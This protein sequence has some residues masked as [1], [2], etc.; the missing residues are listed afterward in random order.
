METR[1]ARR[2]SQGLPRKAPAYAKTGGKKEL[3]T[4]DGHWSG[5]KKG[6]ARG[7]SFLANAGSTLFVLAII[8]T[9]PFIAVIVY[10]RSIAARGSR[11]KA[12]PRIRP[13]LKSIHDDDVRLFLT[14]FALFS[15]FFAS[16]RR[17]DRWHA[18]VNLD[19]SLQ[20]IVQAFQKKGL[21]LIPEIWPSTSKRA[22]QLLG[23]YAAF[24]ALL[25][26]YLPGKRFE[27]TTTA[28]G[29]VPVYKA[30][31][32]QSLVVTVVA[33]FICWR[34]ELTSPK[35]IYDLF[36]EMLAGMA[37]FSIFFCVFLQIKGHVAP[38]DED[39]GSC[40]NPIYDFWWGME[41]YPKLG[42]LNVKQFTNCR[43]GMMA[44]AILPIIFACYQYERDGYLADSVAVTTLLMSVYNFKFFLWE[45]GYFNSMDI[46]HDRAGYYICWGCLVWVPAVYASPALYVASVTPP[47]SLG[48]TR[49]LA[50]TFLGLLSIWVNYDSDL[51][52]QLFR[53]S[54]GKKK[55]WGKKPL[56]IEAEYKV[57]KN[58]EWVTKKSLLLASGW[59]GVARHF[60]YLPEITASFF[61]TA[62]ALFDKLPPYL[63]VV[64]LTILLIDRSMRDDLRCSLKYGKHWKKYCELVP[65]KIVPGI[66]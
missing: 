56:M 4:K 46:Q 65:Y 19:G 62:P 26:V 41:L 14:P 63:Y 39:S 43:F 21:A 48:A 8:L 40:G 1:G 50:I 25:Q 29:N 36:G 10:V 35:E 49:S 60:H 33:F 66:F 57:L 44:W 58:D 31:G 32:V 54:K 18:F 22:W 51:Q 28:N 9:T 6:G 7:D 15:S 59:W 11:P 23:S 16:S 34:F 64:F 12:R 55:V 13:R 42:P 47:V 20:A 3:T 53:A 24:E 52:R 5:A 61:W 38:T 17:N 2:K 30:N 27:A 37:I 45:T